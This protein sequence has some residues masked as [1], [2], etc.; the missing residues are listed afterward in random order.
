MSTRTLDPY[1]SMYSGGVEIASTI[2]DRLYSRFQ[3]PLHQRAILDYL[4]LT[5]T[6]PDK[7]VLDIGCW[8]GLVYAIWSRK[9]FIWNDMTFLDTSEYLLKQARHLMPTTSLQSKK[10]IV[11]NGENLEFDDE[12]FDRT[13]AHTVLNHTTDPRLL[14]EEMMRVTKSG[15][16]VVIFDMETDAVI[17]NNLIWNHWK[18]LFS[19]WEDKW[20]KTLSYNKNIKSEYFQDAIN[21]TKALISHISTWEGSIDEILTQLPSDNIVFTTRIFRK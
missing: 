11:G 7:K 17:D 12:V 8:N 10:F 13:I 2:W 21:Q 6:T 9:G 16:F 4:S 1:H 3:D 14:I 15:W 20:Y 18:S 5:F 19:W